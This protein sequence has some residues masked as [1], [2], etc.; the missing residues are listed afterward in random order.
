MLG[1]LLSIFVYD[2][3]HKIMDEPQAT[4]DGAAYM[5]RCFAVVFGKKHVAHLTVNQGENGMLMASAHQGDAFPMPDLTVLYNICGSLRN[6]RPINDLTA[7]TATAP[8]TL[9]ALL[10]ASQMVLKVASEGFVSIDRQ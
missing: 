6:T 5:F 3:R 9:M 1:K 2:S 8:I 4:D 10:L 7:L